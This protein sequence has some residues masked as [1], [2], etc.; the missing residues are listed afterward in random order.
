M[1]TRYKHSVLYFAV[2]L[3]IAI[4]SCTKYEDIRRPYNNIERFSV[5]G[6]GS[7]DSINAVISGDDIVVYWN[8][9]SESPATITPSIDISAG[10]SISPASGETVSFSQSTVYTVTAED[11]TQRQYT[12]KPRLNE[13]VPI[14]SDVPSVFRWSWE[15][16]LTLAVNGEY[17]L[18]SGDASNIRVYAQR[19]RDGYEFDLLVDTELT[20]GTQVNLTLPKITTEQDSGLHR[21]WVQVGDFP[22]NSV[23]VWISQPLMENVVTS[24]TFPES[25]SPVYIGDHVTLTFHTSLDMEIFTKYFN[26]STLS[27]TINN[28]FMSWGGSNWVNPYS[29]AAIAPV[30][31]FIDNVLKL[32]ITED[33]FG[34]YTNGYYIDYIK[35]YFHYQSSAEGA[36]ATTALSNALIRP[37][38]EATRRLTVLSRKE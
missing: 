14:I 37:L 30:A 17:F 23:D 8:A 19:L 22:S 21:I 34:M 15:T 7:L 1:K 13:A 10:S 27:P 2:A 9:Q 4:N 11:G 18:E 16:P 24:I 25:G 35:P 26:T 5:A 20:T 36:I 6:Y 12:L 38:D 33:L 3:C 29:P 32:E 31:S 28:V